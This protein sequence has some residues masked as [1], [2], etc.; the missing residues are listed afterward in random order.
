MSTTGGTGSG[1]K[2][3]THASG[4]L[5][6]LGS[7]TEVDTQY[8]ENG[9]A[10]YLCGSNNEVSGPQGSGNGSTYNPT[11]CPGTSSIY[12]GPAS[13]FVW[14]AGATPGSIGLNGSLGSPYIA[15][16]SS[17]HYD[18][19]LS[20]GL[21]SSLN[22]GVN[23]FG[24]GPAYSGSRASIYGQWGH[25]DWYSGVSRPMSGTNSYG[26]VVHNAI[27]NPSAPTLTAIGRT[28]TTSVPYGLVCKDG[29]GGH[30]LVSS[31][32]TTVNGPATL[33]ALLTIAP[34][35]GGS[36]FV[37][38]DV[39]KTFTISGGG[40]SG[41]TG[42]ISSV[43]GGAVTG[44]TLT[45]AGSRYNTIPYPGGG[46]TNI[47]STTCAS[48]TG[49]G[50]TVAATSAAI[51]IALPLVDGCASWT[52][53]ETDTGHALQTV[54]SGATGSDNV[55]ADIYDFGGAYTTVSWS[56]TRNT[57]GDFNLPTGL[58]EQAGDPISRGV[59]ILSGSTGSHSFARAYSIRPVC[60]AIDY[61]NG[62]HTFT[63]A[64]TTSVVSVSAGSSGD[65]IAWE[66]GPSVN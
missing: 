43:S 29:N 40:G 5:V 44:V 21:S 45:A 30:T 50:L 58:I 3:N 38:G 53:L 15:F 18:P 19:F 4:F 32:T 17:Y 34:S 65:A 60:T 33:G 62:T 24:N 37:R 12:G 16:F 1:L 52:V 39:G 64:W 13:N 14:G 63:L 61:S 6:L 28:G 59:I 36:G 54:S 23:L 27:A 46:A 47:F 31:P 49:R 8:E 25:S 9:T 20:L 48:C 55:S 66:C 42:T 7:A 35:G 2:V 56:D 57:T 51:K 41:A 11:Y 22:F 10:D 26:A